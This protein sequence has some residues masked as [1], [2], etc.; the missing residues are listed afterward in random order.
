VSK[1]LA[2]VLED[3]VEAEGAAVER[4][5]P[6]GVGSLLGEILVH[7]LDWGRGDR[8]A[9]DQGHEGGGQ[10]GAK[11]RAD[12]AGIGEGPPKER[13]VNV[14]HAGPMSMDRARRGSS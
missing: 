12:A 10:D 5:T 4:E 1:I 14:G 9:I 11:E 2:L 7:E 8:L 3:Q 6:D 13:V